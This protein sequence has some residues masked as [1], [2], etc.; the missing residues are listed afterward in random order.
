MIDLRLEGT[1]SLAGRERL[2]RALDDLRAAVCCLRV[3]DSRLYLSPSPEDLEAI[4]RGGF[5]RVA[6]ETLRD[7][8]G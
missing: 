3:D 6:A 2:A 1:L 5:V 4:A 7:H 8:G